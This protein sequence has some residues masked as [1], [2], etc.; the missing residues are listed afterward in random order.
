MSTP[1]GW[2]SRL[3]TIGSA[4]V[5]CMS[6][7]AGQSTESSDVGQTSATLQ[8]APADPDGPDEL[9]FRWMETDAVDLMS[10]DGT[11]LRAAIE[12]Y[13]R[14]YDVAS[15]DGGYPGFLTAVA[16]AATPSSAFNGSLRVPA[17]GTMY[18]KV[19]NWEQRPDAVREAWYCTYNNL[20]GNRNERAFD[21]GLPYVV[22]S[23]E[24]TRMAWRIE[25]LVGPDAS[26]ERPPAD[27][28]GTGGAPVDDVFGDWKL[29]SIDTDLAQIGSPLA[30]LCDGQSP[31]TPTGWPS[32]REAQFSETPPPA[33]PPW[34]GWPSDPV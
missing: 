32:S 4:L 27:Q 12:S 20:V 11:F 34:P 2:V 28:Y 3:A 24:T 26:P 22:G 25:Y 33:L 14:A 5:L 16:D 19:V 6:C 18:L 10:M 21:G 29:I 31:G 30:T 15:P 17:I 1:R 9:S 7:S 8:T 13:Q 23:G